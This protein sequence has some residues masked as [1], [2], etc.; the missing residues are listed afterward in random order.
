M[1]TPCHSELVSESIYR[2]RGLSLFLHKMDS[3]LRWVD[4][5]S[6]RDRHFRHGP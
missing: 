5:C 6:M 2:V 4:K 1:T 3:S